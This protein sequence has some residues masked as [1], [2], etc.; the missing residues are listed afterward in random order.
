MILSN[1]ILAERIDRVLKYLKAR[2]I[3]QKMVG[4]RINYTSLSKVKDHEKYPQVVIEKHTRQEILDALLSEFGLSYNEENDTVNESGIPIEK[5]TLQDVM[6][7]VMYY[8]SFARELVGMAWI[9]I[10]DKRKVFIDYRIEEHWE[11]TFEVVENYSFITV[12]KR[13]ITTPVKKLICLFSG[14]MKY[15]RP[16]LLGTYS[17]VKRDGFP[18]AGKALL[19]RVP[20]K[21]AVLQKFEND[22]DKRI[23]SY[24]QNTVFTTLTYTPNNLDHLPNSPSLR[25]LEGSYRFIISLPEGP[26]RLGEITISDSQKASLPLEQA[27]YS[28]AV[29]MLD[30]L[31]LKIELRGSSSAGMHYFFLHLRLQTTEQETIYSGKLV[32]NFWK[33]SFESYAC[34]LVTNS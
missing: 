24:L 2:K 25:G 27:A 26:L 33:S 32:S 4:E 16:I 20:D 14:T 13:G 15:G 3:T 6:H 12:E 5:K 34:Q 7:Y 11:G 21:E 10:I 29:E 9:R 22:V 8:Y 23:V 1:R 19:E 31:N 17:T 28:G 18:A 30:I